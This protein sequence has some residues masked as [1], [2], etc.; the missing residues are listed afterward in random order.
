ME[1]WFKRFAR[2]KPYQK[3][4]LLFLVVLLIIFNS[5]FENFIYEYIFPVFDFLIND[6]LKRAKDSHY[7]LLLLIFGGI[8]LYYLSKLSDNK[9]I[10]PFFQSTLFG[11][12]IFF[13]CLYRIG[14]LKFDNG[15]FCILLPED[16]NFK[17]TDVIIIF[18]T[19]IWLTPYLIREGEIFLPTNKAKVLRSFIRNLATFILGNITIIFYLIFAIFFYFFL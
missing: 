2:I 17:Y 12:T 7:I 13:Y 8:Y 15:R 11:L 4:M 6:S 5:F 3:V 1:S 9:E 18:L 16:S 14:A 10:I 19:L